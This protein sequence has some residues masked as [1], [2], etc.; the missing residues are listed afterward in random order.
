MLWQLGYYLSSRPSKLKCIKQQSQPHIKYSYSSIDDMITITCQTQGNGTGEVVLGLIASKLDAKRIFKMAEQNDNEYTVTIAGQDVRDE[1]VK[2]WF[3]FGQI[4]GNDVTLSSGLVTL[5][6]PV[7]TKEPP[8]N[9]HAYY[10]ED[11]ATFFL[12]WYAVRDVR[13]YMV[14]ISYDLRPT[15]G[16]RSC[17]N[18]QTTC[19][20]LTI[21]M[22]REMLN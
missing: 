18:T 8:Q 16:K 2:E 9:L 13:I 4:M 5:A 19:T 7:H 17:L 12:N 14:K 6:D 10:D 11:N 22:K 21:D 15:G 1:D 20:S 3:V